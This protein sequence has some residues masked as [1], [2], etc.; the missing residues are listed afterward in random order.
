MSDFI[1]D[2]AISEGVAPDC[3]HFFR[4]SSLPLPQTMQPVVE[5]FWTATR[6]ISPAMWFSHAAHVCFAAAPFS[7][8]LSQGELVYRLNLVAV[9]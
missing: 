1:T 3:R 5:A 9:F 7:L 8:N 4:V 6:C 2:T